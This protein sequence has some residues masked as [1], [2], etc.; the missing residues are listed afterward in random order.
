MQQFNRNKIWTVTTKISGSA[1]KYAIDNVNPLRDAQILS[2]RTRRSSAT[3]R[4]LQGEQIVNDANF[5]GCLLRLKFGTTEVVVLPLYYIE[6]ATLNDPATGYPLNISGLDLSL[7]EIEIVENVTL[8]TG[9][10]V[11][12]V[13]E[14]TTEKK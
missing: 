10:V 8:N 4:T 6:R 5:D 1:R 11:E 9:N 12:L 14:Y 2:V 3:A 7:C 13:F